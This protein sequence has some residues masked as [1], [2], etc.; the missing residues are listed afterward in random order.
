MSGQVCFDFY[1]I[2]GFKI[3]SSQCN[4]PIPIPTPVIPPIPI[5]TPDITPIP[6]PTPDITPIPIPTPDITPIPIKKDLVVECEDDKKPK[7]LK[8][9]N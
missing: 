1:L 6:I 4:P 8:N 5:P 2:G 9:S 7:R 3:N